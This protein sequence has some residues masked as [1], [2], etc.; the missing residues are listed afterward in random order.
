MFYL[1]PLHTCTLEG[2]NKYGAS[3]YVGS[4]QKK[5]FQEDQIKAD[6]MGGACNIHPRD[7]KC[8]KIWQENSKG[9]D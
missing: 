8:I 7:K 1:E 6:E 5:Y 2:K 9:R 4:F 3:L